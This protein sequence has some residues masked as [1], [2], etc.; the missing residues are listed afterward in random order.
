MISEIPREVLEVTFPG[1]GEKVEKL[2]KKQRE[3][4]FVDAQPQ[5]QEKEESKGRKGP[6]SSILDTLY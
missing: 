1:S 2:I 5:E 3:S 6:L 4:H